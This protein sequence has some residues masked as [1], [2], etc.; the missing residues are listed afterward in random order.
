VNRLRFKNLKLERNG[1][2]SRRL[3]LS[4]IVVIEV[5][6]SRE[7]CI[8]TLSGFQSIKDQTCLVGFGGPNCYIAYCGSS[9]GFWWPILLERSRL[10]GNLKSCVS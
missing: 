4:S 3:P 9:V 7:R 10:R 1:E 8:S 5:S 2:G 6:R